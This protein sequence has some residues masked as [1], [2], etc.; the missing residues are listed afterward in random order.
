MSKSEKK[1][2]NVEGL[3]VREGKTQHLVV[4]HVYAVTP[5]KA[6]I[7]IKTKQAVK[8]S[9]EVTKRT[10]APILGGVEEKPASKGGNKGKG[11]NKSKDKD[12]AGTGKGDEN[13]EENEEDLTA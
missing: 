3:K 10:P 12:K 7:L 11:G 2:V 8:T 4:G 5:E 13:P 9:K 1:L 6:E